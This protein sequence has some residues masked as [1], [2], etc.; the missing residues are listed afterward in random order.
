VQIVV[1]RDSLRDTM[2]QYLIDQIGKTPNVRLRTRTE[3]ACVEGSGRVE[4]VGLKSV[5]TGTVEAEDVDAVFVF[6]GTRP[7]SD[8]LPAGV[9]RDSR[10]FVLTGRDLMANEAFARLWKEPREPLPLETS[11]PGVFAAGDIRASAMNRVA[12]AVGEGSMVVRFV[13]EYLAL[14]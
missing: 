3:L 7:R 8:W 9:L 2:S 4:R 1:R 12:S 11:V 10:G 5:D 6:I 13:H 14:T